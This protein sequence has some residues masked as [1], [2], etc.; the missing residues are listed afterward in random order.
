MRGSVAGQNKIQKST[1]FCEIQITNDII[2]KF[3]PC[4]WRL[5]KDNQSRKDNIYS[6]FL[7]NFP[8][9]SERSLA[10][11]CWDKIPDIDN[12][13]EE[14]FFLAHSCRGVNLWYAAPRQRHCDK[15]S[16]LFFIFSTGYRTHNL[17]L[18]D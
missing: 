5:S 11:S 14:K 3:V 8:S 15:T 2:F 1:Y 17:C 6:F 10:F 16:F 4:V 12:L 13:K 9:M 18:P 7:L